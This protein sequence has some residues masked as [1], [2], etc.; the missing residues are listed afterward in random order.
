MI[1]ADSGG[2]LVDKT[3][4]ASRTLIANLLGPDKMFLGR[5]M[6]LV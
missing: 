5:L 6:K 1:D 3:P 2:A 4:Q